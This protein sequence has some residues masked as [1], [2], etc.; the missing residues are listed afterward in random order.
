MSNFLLQHEL[1]AASKTTPEVLEVMDT[2]SESKQ[3]SI[4]QLVYSDNRVRRVLFGRP[5]YTLT[6]ANVF[7]F[8]QKKAQTAHSLL[9]RL[10]HLENSTTY[11]QLTSCLVCKF[12][13]QKPNISLLIDFVIYL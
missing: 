7:F 3:Q 9:D 11:E 12:L 5:L 8:P 2:S 13:P 1:E 4:A 10:N 6:Y